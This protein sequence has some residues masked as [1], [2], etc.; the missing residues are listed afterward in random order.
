MPRAMKLTTPISVLA[1]ASARACLLAGLL[2]SAC[3]APDASAGPA[4]APPSTPAPPPIP[5]VNPPPPS[6]PPPQE[7]PPATPAPPVAEAKPEACDGGWVCVKINFATGKVDKRD[8]KLMGDPKIESTWSKQ[9]DGRTVTFDDFSKGPVEFTLHRNQSKKNDVVV[10]LVKGG[11]TI[12]IDRR[13][14]GDSD[15]THV[16]AIAA[17]Q[18][19]NLLIDMLYLR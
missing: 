8:T 6:T 9:S 11:T 19:G 18:D 3:G 10:K 2:C 12:T 4:V 17:E 5:P 1:F 7:S 13:E 15:F 14:G 16:G